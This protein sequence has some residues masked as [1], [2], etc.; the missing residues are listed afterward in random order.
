MR[1]SVHL[2][3]AGIGLIKADQ[4]FHQGAFSGAVL[5]EES[6]YASGPNY[7]RYAVQSEIG[8]ETLGHVEQCE[9]WSVHR[10]FRQ[11]ALCKRLLIDA[12]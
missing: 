3:V 7:Q 4:T 10:I 1:T 6:V 5:A 12:A 9:L 8:S 11:G 2:Y